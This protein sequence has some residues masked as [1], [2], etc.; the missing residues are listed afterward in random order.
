MHEQLCAPS[1][2]YKLILCHTRCRHAAPR[3]TALLP[4]PRDPIWAMGHGAVHQHQRLH[5]LY[6]MYH[7]PHTAYTPATGYWGVLLPRWP[8]IS[9]RRAASPPSCPAA[10]SGRCS[11]QTKTNQKRRPKKAAPSAE[12]RSPFCCLLP[13]RVLFCQPAV[14]TT[15]HYLMSPGYWVHAPVCRCAVC[16]S[17]DLTQSV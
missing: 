14:A 7:V 4:H 16:C 10:G 3:T 1:A 13:F 17:K 5:I 9:L 15:R 12:F 11:G 2:L 8:L 6:I